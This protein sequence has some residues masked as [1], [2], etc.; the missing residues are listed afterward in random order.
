[1]QRGLVIISMLV[2]SATLAGF[3]TASSSSTAGPAA[4]K[5]IVQTAVAAGE[6]T[7]LVSLAKK[8]GLAGALSTKTLTVFAPTDAAFARVPKSTLNALAKDKKALRAVRSITQS[9][10]RCPRRRSSG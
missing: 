9:P 6:F 4:K 2:A 5:N 1:M 8:A 3:A 10:A 7:A